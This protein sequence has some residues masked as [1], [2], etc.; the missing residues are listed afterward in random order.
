MSLRPGSSRAAQ[1]GSTS[2][3][4]TSRDSKDSDYKSARDCGY[5]SVSAAPAPTSRTRLLDADRGYDK[6]CAFSDSE[7]YSYGGGNTKRAGRGDFGDGE[8]PYGRAYSDFEV[9]DDEDGNKGGPSGLGGTM[10]TDEF[11]ETANPNRDKSL[12]T[13]RQRKK[14]AARTKGGEFQARRR[15]RRVYF[16]CISSDVDVQRVF[17]D[18]TASAGAG[19][20]SSGLPAG[21]KF[22]LYPGGDV[23]H[24]YKPG[25]EAYMDPVYGGGHGPGE[26]MGRSQSAPVP[27][28]TERIR[29]KSLRTEFDKD[30]ASFPPR[31]GLDGR[32]RRASIESQDGVYDGEYHDCDFDKL[33]GEPFPSPSVPSSHGPSAGSATQA[34]ALSAQKFFD[35]QALRISAAGAQEAFVFDFGAVVFWGFSRGEEVGL[36]KT[37]RL[38]VTKGLV[39][40]GEFES[41]EVR[42]MIVARCCFLRACVHLKFTS[43]QL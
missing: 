43:L 4:S 16:C 1:Q 14:L 9:T 6:Y 29:E 31:T 22:Q 18:L 15:K 24:V 33:D 30:F 32:P 17:D 19:L 40:P 5:G 12:R 37:I 25:V 38:F 21:W 27:T 20:G 36:L 2:L 7:A 10:G 3:N 23:L 34:L 11:G 39:G 42:H 41:G 28:A 35:N 8:A 26:A 13:G